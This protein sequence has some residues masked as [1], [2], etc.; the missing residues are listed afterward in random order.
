MKILHTSDWHL[1]AALR[2]HY[3]RAAELFD[4]IEKICELA[5]ENNVELL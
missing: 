3:D 5:Q 1:G 2:G 4:Q